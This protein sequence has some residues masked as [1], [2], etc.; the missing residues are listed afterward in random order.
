MASAA[1]ALVRAIAATA[2]HCGDHPHQEPDR[3]WQW[4]SL[5]QIAPALPLA[6]R[7]TIPRNV[8]TTCCVYVANGTVRR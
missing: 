7:A 6:T 4:L 2:K 8:W 1:Y 3:R 5:T